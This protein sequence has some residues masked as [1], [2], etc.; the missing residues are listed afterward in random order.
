MGMFRS[1]YDRN[2]V[3]SEEAM[4]DRAKCY[5]D[6]RPESLAGREN[7]ILGMMYPLLIPFTL[8]PGFL[9]RVAVARTALLIIPYAL[10]VVSILLTGI[11]LVDF[12][13]KSRGAVNGYVYKN[14][15][16]G[17]QVRTALSGIF[18][19]LFG[20]SQLVWMLR[21]R[22][23]LQATEAGVLL[24]QLCFLAV[25]LFFWRKLGLIISNWHLST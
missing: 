6:I 5:R 11:T 19:I 10:E 12:L 4:Q 21:H 2:G 20:L 7:R 9:P 18:G 17:L 15:F 3:L 23:E 24:T 14:T 16:M 1:P 25:L 13:R 22:A 8:L